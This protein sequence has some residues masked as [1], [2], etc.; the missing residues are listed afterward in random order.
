MAQEGAAA[1]LPLGSQ[2]A[3]RQAEPV[4]PHSEVGR[5]PMLRVFVSYSRDD[6]AFADQLVAALE[7]CGFD[8]TIDRHDITGGE[9]WE[10][11]LGA[12]IR[13]ADTVV[14]V[15][16]PSSVISARCKWEVEQAQALGKRILPIVCRPFDEAAPEQLQALNYIFFCEEP[17]VP[18]SGFGSGLARLVTA[19]N[20][21]HDWIARHTRILQRATEWDTGGRKREQLL[22]GG[23]I[24]AA[25][26]WIVARKATAPAIVPLQLEYVRE[27]EAEEERRKSSERQQL[28]QIRKAQ[29]ERAVAL[30]ASELA[31]AERETALLGAQKAQ[32]AWLWTLGIASVVGLGLAAGA[33]V[34]WWRAFDVGKQNA[35]LLK[36]KQELL[37]KA[38]EAKQQVL[39]QQGR[40]LSQAERVR[41][42]DACKEADAVA[43]QLATL[44]DPKAWLLANKRYWELYWGSMMVLEAHQK[45]I[46]NNRSD[47]EAAMV[48]FGNQLKRAEL[49]VKNA[50]S[51]PV[52]RSVAQPALPRSELTPLHKGV[53]DACQA[54]FRQIG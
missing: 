38:D 40:Q 3:A 43:L 32:R 7:P 49:E 23:E 45:K 54:F 28:E 13:D 44:R 42:I 31:Q 47:V 2:V 11:R 46:S 4:G 6:L 18:G 48:R 52:Q 34:G 16:S 12:L 36:E 37:A 29:Q 53:A 35:V 20:T 22:W 24:A 15:L 5:H 27:S 50:A 8:P 30:K 51:S 21:D 10:R 33:G 26:D 1:P 41:M 17:R 25:K 39:S 19:L 14:F 9:D